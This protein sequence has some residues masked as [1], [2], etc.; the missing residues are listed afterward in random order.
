MTK[1]A[2]LLLA[3]LFLNP[4][5]LR[6]DEPE[7]AKKRDADVFP[8]AAAADLGI[9]P[10]ALEKLR[11]R[12]E[13]AVS[14][15]V[16]IVKDGRLVA[17]WDFGR[18][19]GPIEAMSATKSIVNLAIGR[20]IDSGKIESLDQPVSDFYPEWKQ[21]RKKLITVRHLLNHTSGLQNLPI[22]T[23]EIYP[24]PDFVQLALAA[25]LSDDPGSKFAYNNKALNLLAGVVQRAS[26]TRMDRYIG[27][28]IFE[29][30][31]INDFDWTL[32]KAGNPHGMSGLQIRALDLAKIGQMMLDEGSW[33]GKQI[34]SKD[35]VRKSVEPSQ[36]LYPI[37]GLLWWLDRGPARFSVD[38]AFIKFYKDRGITAASVAKLEALRNEP[39]ELAAFYDAL[40]PIVRA[41][42]VFNAKLEL[43]YATP[44][45]PRPILRAD[46]VFNAKPM[47]LLEEP[48]P[49][50]PIVEGP[51]RSYEARGYLGQFL[52]VIPRDRLVAVRQRRGPDSQRFSKRTFSEFSEMVASL[53]N[54]PPAKR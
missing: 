21:G 50:K 6:G 17:D 33:K 10:A 52:V 51:V 42:E 15:A 34:L 9:D 4:F 32:D 18:E 36:S 30:L 43:A 46:N 8:R 5:P 11:K 48:P 26:G 54:K 29:P 19:R 44:G 3:T 14:D 23:L 35:W 38:D 53:V 24:S 27:K 28:E 45:I 41:D 1:T 49:M 16:V 37:Y 20:L 40:R 12:A 7:A 2:L 25:E 47:E 13:E 31:G 22:T 39:V